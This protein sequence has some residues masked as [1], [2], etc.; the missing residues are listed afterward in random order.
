LLH[1]SFKLAAKKGTRY[2]DLLK[3][4]S[5]IIGR[6]VYENLYE[7]HMKPLFLG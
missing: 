3:E 1:V 7:R 4:H 2:T 5:E 6:N